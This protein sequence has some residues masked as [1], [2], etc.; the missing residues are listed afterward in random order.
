[1]KGL[2]LPIGLLAALSVS[3]D[4]RP[5]SRSTATPAAS[6]APAAPEAPASKTFAPCTQQQKKSLDE[7]VDGWRQDG[8]D[9][10]GFMTNRANQVVGYYAWNDHNE[11][12]AEVC[13]F[14]EKPNEVIANE[15]SSWDA[16]QPS[17]FSSS[18]S[19]WAV[20]QSY[21]ISQDEGTATIKL[22][23]IMP[24][25]VSVQF[26]VWNSDAT[27]PVRQDILQFNK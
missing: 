11:M 8:I 17:T 14:L 25:A 4:P 13:E 16:A 1:M 21:G 22:L 5:R 12:H 24:K 27:K 7:A 19:S 23:K 18:P 26:T 9:K 15:W 6:V 3:A 10:S 20:N 2:L